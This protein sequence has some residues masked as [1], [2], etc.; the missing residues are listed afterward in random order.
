MIT[1]SVLFII[2]LIAMVVIFTSNTKKLNRMK[3]QY[4]ALYSI[5]KIETTGGRLY[6]IIFI[7]KRIGFVTLIF[8]STH[9]QLNIGIM[10]I[11]NLL[12]I[13]FLLT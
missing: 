8:L 7:L 6:P 9:T 13:I 1:F 2:F 4:G 11:I 5:L 12:S 10:T 3:P